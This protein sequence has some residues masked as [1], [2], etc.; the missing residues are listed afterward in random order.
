MPRGVLG[1]LVQTSQFPAPPENVVVTVTS[2]NSPVS[3]D[4]EKYLSR[5]SKQFLGNLA[6]RGTGTDDQNAA[7]G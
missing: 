1:L 5:R 4:R 6:A 2:R 7:W 3:S